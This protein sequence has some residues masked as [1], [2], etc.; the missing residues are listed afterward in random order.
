MKRMFSILWVAI[1]VVLLTV[2]GMALES[3]EESLQAYANIEAAVIA[4]NGTDEATGLARFPDEFAGAWYDEENYL[5]L[6]LTDLSAQSYYEERSGNPEVLRFAQVKYSLWD[7]LEIQAEI[8]ATYMET[9]KYG[10]YLEGAMVDMPTNT[11][12]LTVVQGGVEK[13]L[14]YYRGIYG[15]A[16]SAVEGQELLEVP[17]DGDVEDV[18]RIDLWVIIMVAVMALAAVALFILLVVLIIRRRQEKRQEK[19]T[20]TERAA[21]QAA[22]AAKQKNR[23]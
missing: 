21:A 13:A 14:E 15:D 3:T 4:E 9:E 11:L 22:R 16:I 18:V 19:K 1:L 20:Q 7:L 2:P 10:F 8:S 5:V 12:Q 6:A 23:K 17:A